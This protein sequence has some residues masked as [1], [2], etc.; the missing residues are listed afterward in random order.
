MKKKHKTYS[1][2]SHIPPLAARMWHDP[3]ARPGMVNWYNPKQLIVTGIKTLLSTLFGL[4]SDFRLIERVISLLV[5]PVVK[6]S[7]II[8]SKNI[9]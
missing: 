9:W 5:F 7:T 1:K 8:H 2:L 4:Y 3:T 6:Q